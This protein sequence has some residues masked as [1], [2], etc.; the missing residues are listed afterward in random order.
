[1]YL[2][3][4][5]INSPAAQMN[6]PWLPDPWKIDKQRESPFAELTPHLWI[7]QS[8]EAKLKGAGD[9]LPCSE[10][11]CLGWWHVNKSENK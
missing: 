2:T 10:F 1:M 9:R 11:L 8:E 4:L 3:Q 5:L 7:A 6:S